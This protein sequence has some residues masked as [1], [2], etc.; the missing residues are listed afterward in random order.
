MTYMYMMYINI[1]TCTYKVCLLTLYSF[2]HLLTVHLPFAGV[3]AGGQC[4]LYC[5]LDTLDPGFLGL[6][7]GQGY[8]GVYLVQ[9][10]S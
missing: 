10:S 8:V 7:L 3:Q 4:D 9:G 5:L 1:I 2:T 6:L